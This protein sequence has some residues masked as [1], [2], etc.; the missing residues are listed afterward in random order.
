MNKPT[1]N[2]Q[3]LSRAEKL[4]LEL[5]ATPGGSGQEGRVMELIVKKLRQAGAPASAIQF[6]QAHRRSRHGGEIG[7]LAC[8]LPGTLRGPRRMLMAHTDTVP[9]CRGAK[10]VRRGRYV[11]PADKQTALGADDRA[12]CG[13][14]LATA[15]EILRSKLPHPP[16]TFFWTVQEE[17]GIHGARNARLGML[18]KPKLAFNFDGGAAD[19]ITVGATG[20]YRMDIRVTGIAAHAGNAPEQGAS[21]IAIASLAVAQLHRDGWHGQ[22]EKNGRFGTSN[23]GVIQGGDATNVVT[24]L[25]ELKA[26]ARSHDK[27]FRR[28]IVPAMERAFTQ[29]AREGRSQE[30]S[31]GKGELDGRLDYEAYRLS[32]DEPCVLAAE[33]AVTQLGA[34]PI[35]AITNGGIDANWLTERGIPT[36]SFGCGQLNVHTAN[37]RLDLVEYGRAC[38][39]GLLLATN[40]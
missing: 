13:V 22:I 20:G 3:R 2:K 34:T 24:P 32:D 8:K 21:A 10:P 31:G 12:G 29:A 4:V 27:A 36:A 11:V 40:Q 26:E 1:I 6:D 33:R 28:Q 7:N 15:V 18:G 14:V 30:G 9:L 5:L 25:V 17:T 39:I 35:R 16:V 37:E 23:I 19:K 38:Q